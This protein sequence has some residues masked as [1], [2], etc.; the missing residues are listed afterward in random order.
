MDSNI[1]TDTQL[2]ILKDFKEMYPEKYLDQLLKMLKITTSNMA[3]SPRNPTF[4]ILRTIQDS[5]LV[6]NVKTFE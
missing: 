4:E 5:N 2:S 1:N 6:N 3:S